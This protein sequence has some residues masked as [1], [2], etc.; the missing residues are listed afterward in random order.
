MFGLPV[1]VLAMLSRGMLRSDAVRDMAEALPADFQ[2]VKENADRG[3]DFSAIAT[4]T[5]LIDGTGT[6][7]YLREAVEAL[8]RIIPGA[9]HVEL[10]G[11]MHGVTQNRAERGHPDLVAP[12]LL[13]FFA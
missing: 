10:P 9:R 12:L 3:A 8:T 2:V 11:Q 1:P 13:E 5:L 6:R 7:P 4:P